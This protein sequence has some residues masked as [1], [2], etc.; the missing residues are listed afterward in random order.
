MALF[1]VL[2]GDIVT[3]LIVADSLEDAELAS[4]SVCIEYERKEEIE[5]VTPNIGYS[6]DGTNFIVPEVPE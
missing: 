2:S 3:N 4:S 6:W 1:A 5:Y